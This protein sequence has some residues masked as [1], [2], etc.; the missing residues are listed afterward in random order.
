[1]NKGVCFLDTIPRIYLFRQDKTYNNS[2]R[3]T[4]WPA[5]KDKLFTERETEVSRLSHEQ[6]KNAMESWCSQDWF[7]SAFGLKSQCRMKW[8]ESTCS[9]FCR[10]GLASM[11]WRPALTEAKR[12][13]HEIAPY[14]WGAWVLKGNRK[15]C[16]SLGII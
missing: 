3:K 12:L 8:A 7:W 6:S 1:M 14:S 13:K 16:Y 15:Y 10:C 11:A 4:E 2:N 5:T 9:G